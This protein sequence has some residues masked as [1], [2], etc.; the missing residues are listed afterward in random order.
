MTKDSAEAEPPAAMSIM[1]FKK[2]KLKKQDISMKAIRLDNGRVL[3]YD[4]PYHALALFYRSHTAIVL[5]DQH[6]V[7][8]QP[9]M[10]R[11]RRSLERQ[12]GLM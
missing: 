3:P 6:R 4:V 9:L 1:K 10:H 5:C 2:L 8:E 12:R 7:A 11:I